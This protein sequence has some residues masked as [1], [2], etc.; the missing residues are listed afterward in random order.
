MTKSHPAVI[1]FPKRIEPLECTISAVCHFQAAAELRM[2][3]L[4]KLF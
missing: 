1:P 4:H 2:T 3:M